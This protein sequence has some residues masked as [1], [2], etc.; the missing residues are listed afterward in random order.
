MKAQPAA[1]VQ[2]RN[3]LFL[4]N[5][6]KIGAAQPATHAVT[7]PAVPGVGISRQAQRVLQLRSPDARM[8]DTA[9]RDGGNVARRAMRRQRDKCRLKGL[10]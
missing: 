3:Q 8:H 7:Q 5:P 6:K 4:S 2:L 10:L 9:V 1:A